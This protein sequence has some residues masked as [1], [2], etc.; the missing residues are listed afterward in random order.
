MKTKEEI[1]DKIIE[2]TNKLKSTGSTG[3]GVRKQIEILNWVIGG[4]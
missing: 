2:L 3:H 4:N 1:K